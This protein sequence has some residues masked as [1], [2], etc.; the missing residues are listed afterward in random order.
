MSTT[1]KVIIVSVMVAFV[2]MLITGV[3]FI[4]STHFNFDA[5]E[6]S[7]ITIFDGSNGEEVEVTDDAVIKHITDNINRVEYRRGWLDFN[8]G[9]TYT[10]KLYDTDDEL[11]SKLTVRGDSRITYNRFSYVAKEHSIDYEYIGSLFN[12]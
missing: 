7:R 5:D 11:I 3:T 8:M 12:E 10:I 4:P 1:S 2:F 6:V 9:Y